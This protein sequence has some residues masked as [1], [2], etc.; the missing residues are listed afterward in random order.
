MVYKAHFDMA[1]VDDV[2]TVSDLI[3]KENRVDLY[4]QDMETI[5]NSHNKTFK[6]LSKQ[7]GVSEEVIYKVR[8]LFR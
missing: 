8:G 4:A 5:L 6:E 2:S 7:I 3:K 1:N